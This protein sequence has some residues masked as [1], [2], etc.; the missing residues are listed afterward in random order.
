MSKFDKNLNFKPKSCYLF[1]NV[2]L[3]IINSIRFNN[4]FQNQWA[5]NGENV[6]KRLPQQLKSTYWDSLYRQ[7]FW[8]HPN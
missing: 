3:F 1:K 2:L 8:D 7:T 5:K 6:L 4:I